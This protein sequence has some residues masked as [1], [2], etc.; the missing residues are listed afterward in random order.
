MS[1]D[2][3]LSDSILSD[4]VLNTMAVGDSV[5]DGTFCTNMRCRGRRDGC[6]V[7]S[8]GG[9][10]MCTIVRF[11]LSVASFFNQPSINSA[12]VLYTERS[13]RLF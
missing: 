12:Q 6:L 10:M 4:R 1:S 9:V 7:R 8:S 2:S 5:F 11:T 13:R 3:I